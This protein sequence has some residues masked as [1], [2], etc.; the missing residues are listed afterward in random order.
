MIKILFILVS[1]FAISAADD[2]DI[3]ATFGEAKRSHKHVMIFLHKPNC[4]YC[5]TMTLFTLPDEDVEQTIKKDF[6]FVDIDIGTPGEVAF[7]DFKGTKREFA[8]FLGY[9]FYP[10]TVFVDQD[11]EIVYRQPGYKDEDEFLNILR[12]IQSRSYEDMGI[13]DFK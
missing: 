5:E 4:S 7:K 1:I 2:I 12:F 13:E 11:S 6:I 10:T 8:I 9:D 3:D